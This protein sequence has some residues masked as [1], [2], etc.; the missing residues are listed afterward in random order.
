MVILAFVVFC[1]V[2]KKLKYVQKRVNFICD[3]LKAD[4]SFEKYL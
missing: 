2:L 4:G 3:L 1:Y